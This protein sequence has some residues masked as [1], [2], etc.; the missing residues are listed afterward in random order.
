MRRKIKSIEDFDSLRRTIIESRN[1]TEFSITVSSGTCGEARDS[2]E[3]VQ[4]FQEGI[5]ARGLK[6]KGSLKVT[7]CHGFCQE[8][9]V[10]II[11]KG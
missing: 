11:K 7:G 3:V 9:P 5:E 6:D 8:E 1:P 10:V 4:A 2:L